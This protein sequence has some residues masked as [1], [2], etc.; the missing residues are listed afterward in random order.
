MWF[1][2]GEKGRCNTL[3]WNIDYENILA[4]KPSLLLSPLDWLNL[5]SQSDRIPGGLFGGDCWELQE[6]GVYR[7]TG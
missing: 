5:W 3:L 6:V 4:V 2:N 1:Q 7:L